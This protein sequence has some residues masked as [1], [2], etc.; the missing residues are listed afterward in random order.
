MQ[1]TSCRIVPI[2]FAAIL[3]AALACGSLLARSGGTARTEPEQR[4][5]PPKP[6]Q[7]IY[8]TAER[9][10]YTPSR[11]RIKKGTIVEIIAESEDTAHGFYIPTAGIEGMIPARGKGEM[12][13]R[14]EAA[15]SGDYIFECSR[16][17]GAG[18]N[19]MRGVLIVED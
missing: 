4:G 9:F 18:H 6:V 8:L 2:I 14:I 5:A 3:L 11:I 10:S 19:T 13:L 7:Q 16:A 12:R 1:Q 15:E 17:C